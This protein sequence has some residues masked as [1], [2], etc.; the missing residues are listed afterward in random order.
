MREEITE[1][2]TQNLLRVKNLV[3]IYTNKLAGA[4]QGRRSIGKTDVLRAA[5]VFLHATLEDFL[6]GITLW[7]LPR[8]DAG[9]LDDIPL[10][11]LGP[12]NRPEKFLLGKLFQHSGKTIDA[13]IEESIK[14]YLANTTYNNTDDIA[15]TLRKIGVQPANV[16]AEFAI[17]LTLMKRRHHIVHQADKNDHLGQGNHSAKSIGVGDLERWIPAVERFC[18]SVLQEIPIEPA[19]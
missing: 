14:N 8:N 16:N 7:K 17:L 5:T 2:L 11:G 13:V 10:S 15:S 1:R 9:I 6:R 18:N 12:S 4:G 19:A 3:S